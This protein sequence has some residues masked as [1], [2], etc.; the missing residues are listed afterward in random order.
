[1]HPRTS[2]R[3]GCCSAIISSAAKSCGRKLFRVA[4][5]SKKR[6]PW[7]NREVKEAIRAKKDAFKALLQDRSSFDLQSR[8]TKVRK[9]ATSTIKKFK[10]KL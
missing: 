1:M 5:D 10:E 6:T 2:R 7:W 8:Y 4:G 3:N 9:A